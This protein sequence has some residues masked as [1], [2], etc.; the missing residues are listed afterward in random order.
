[1]TKACKSKENESD[2]E[3]TTVAVPDKDSLI[4]PGRQEG[5]TQLHSSVLRPGKGAA[6]SAGLA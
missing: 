5:N 1:M 3:A 6:A 2:F 4:H